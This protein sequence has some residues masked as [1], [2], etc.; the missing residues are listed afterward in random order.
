M[1]DTVALTS[2]CVNRQLYAVRSFP[3]QLYKETICQSHVTASFCCSQVVTV[4]V[5]LK[6]SCIKLAGSEYI[7]IT[8]ASMFSHSSQ[9]KVKFRST[10]HIYRHIFHTSPFI[11]PVSESQASLC[12]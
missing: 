4:I 10:L 3:Y 11:V 2:G 5:G 9:L 12:V 6:L 1:N 7:S 8:P